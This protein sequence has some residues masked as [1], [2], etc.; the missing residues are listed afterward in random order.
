[1]LV[2]TIAVPTVIGIILANT[3]MLPNI[4]PTNIVAKEKLQTN[5]NTL[6]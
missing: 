1:M 2:A 3:T 4:V 6:L 5:A